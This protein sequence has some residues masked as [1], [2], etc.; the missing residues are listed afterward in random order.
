MKMRQKPIQ[1]EERILIV[2][3]LLMTREQ[4]YF[5]EVLMNEHVLEKEQEADLK[6][7]Q[8]IRADNAGVP[9]EL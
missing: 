9:F 4:Y 3:L 6:N 5:E 7:E 2:Q 1:K 8:A